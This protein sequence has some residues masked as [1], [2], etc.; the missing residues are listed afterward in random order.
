MSKGLG[1]YIENNLIKYAKVS[2][3]HDNIKVESYGVRIFENI[4]A[5]IK[6]I[7]EETYSFN[8]PI[9]INLAN[10]KY[11]YFD[12][13]G[14]L[15]KKDI[16]RMIE[17]EFE[18]YCEEKNYNKNA[19]ET[20]YAL[21]PNIDDKEKIRTIEIV[22]N[23]I[24]LNRQM[25]PFDGYKLSK[26]L[27]LPMVIAD[28]ADIEKKENALILNMEETATLTT[29]ID[30]KIYDIKSFEV[31]S[32]EVLEKINTIENSY[33]KAYEICK[34]TTIYTAEME[35]MG[36]DQPYLQY[37]IPTI[38]EIRQKLQEAILENS[39]KFD[40]VYLT[41]TLA[42]VNN[43]DLYF[44][45]VLQDVECKILK[46]KFISEATTQVN[47]K[48]YIE[49]NSAIA[50]AVNDLADKVQDL[51]FKK[52]SLNDKLSKMLKVE[53]SEKGKR[54]AETRKD[55]F[56]AKL[57][58]KLNINLDTNMKGQLD[59]TETWLVRI[60]TSLILIMVIFM[61][62]SKIL[63]K[64]MLNKEREIEGL[65]AT[66]NQ[67]ITKVKQTAQSLD[68]KTTKYKSLIKRLDELNDKMSDIAARRNSIPNLLNQLMY[69]IPEAVQLTAIDNT[70][71]KHIVI[72]AQSADY[73]QLGYFVGKIK[74]KKILKDVVSSSGVKNG[75]TISV[76]IEG[77]L[78]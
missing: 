39:T 15:N 5:E 35:N 76:T 73:Q 30:S 51:S 8:I 12:V 68:S 74:T 37:I 55:N 44:Q 19:F 62:F 38:F 60:M 9:S 69:N 48:D 64:Q 27:P 47:I 21:V 71:N 31:G 49:V 77:D 4:S 36:E 57:L 40:K 72:K 11:L 43:I 1:I 46:P 29:V 53:K 25:Q 61:S 50:L 59:Y 45:E 41:G 65:T 16:K 42:T 58:E 14:M 13:F 63:S 70:T 67:E 33:A 75:E 34:N 56:F 26:V 18:T 32:K 78:P 28:V 66:Q 20:R 24:E 7:V 22:A 54:T 2:K 10:E 52:T 6:K 23:K 17:T 3:E